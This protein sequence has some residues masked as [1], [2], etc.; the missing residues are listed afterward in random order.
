VWKLA[1][2]ALSRSEQAAA[3]P[4][5]NELN[6]SIAIVHGSER[7]ASND[8]SLSAMYVAFERWIERSPAA[9]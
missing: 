2:D 7:I 1:L 8:D 4:E 3:S 9:N 5:P 6:A